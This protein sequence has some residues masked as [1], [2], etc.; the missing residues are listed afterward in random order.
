MK[1][2]SKCGIEKEESEFNKDSR[3]R[4]GRYPQ[5]RECRKD[6]AKEYRRRKWKEI[7]R[8]R[9]DRYWKCRDE[10]KRLREENLKQWVSHFKNMYGESPEC[11]ICSRSLK[12]H[13]EGNSGGE[14]CVHFDHR[15]GEGKV[16]KIPPTAWFMAKKLL[17]RYIEIFEN[18]DFG[19]ICRRC[20]LFLPTSDREDWIKNVVRYMKEVE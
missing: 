17:P 18:E 10:A 5:C 14:D 2:C 1:K 19:I 12:W 7:K 8:Y 4:N 15:N 9:K 20:N 3:R 16:I 13:G 6:T 11:Q